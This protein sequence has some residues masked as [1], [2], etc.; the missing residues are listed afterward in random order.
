MTQGSGG[1]YDLSRRELLSAS[2]A[3]GLALATGGCDQFVQAIKDRPTRRN[4]AN[5]SP[6]D[7]ILE[8]YR[9]AIA[10]MQALPTTDQR[11][12]T[13]QASIHYNHCPHTNWFLLP[14]HRMY[15]VYFER[16]CRKLSGDQQFALPYWNWTDDPAVPAVFWPTGDPLNDSTKTIAQGTP[17]L[18]EFVSHAVLEPI[19][20]ETNFLIFGSGKVTGQRDPGSQGPLEATPHNNVHGQIGGHMATYMSPLDP[21]FW[22]HHCMLDFCWVDW[23]L[24]RV[25]NNPNDPVWNNLQITDFVDE[26][27]QPVSLPV[28]ITPLYPIFDYQYEPSQIGATV[29]HR[30]A[31]AKQEQEQLKTF[32]QQGG[33]AEIPVLQRFR[34]EGPSDVGVGR[35]SR[36]SIAVQSSALRDAIESTGDQ[37]L[38][39]T[40]QQV[41]PPAEAGFFV[42]VFV[43]EPGTV[44][45]ETP[46]TDPHY[47][48]SFA[49]FIGDHGMNEG[50]HM[51]PAGFVVDL[52]ETLR[53][54]SRGGGLGQAN[55]LEIQ[56][57]PV[58]YPGRP[59]KELSFTVGG[60][61][62]AIARL[63]RK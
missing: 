40:I 44:T 38:L 32:V 52:T 6:N 20:Q 2:G 60:L 25:N 13:N 28:S 19:L 42:R 8:A 21:I 53:R 62:L 27:N 14:W 5:L 18:A 56:L 22:T 34:V 12:W 57:V 4:I 50:M 35:G 15:L 58:P 46:I 45:P 61:E 41:Q 47:A 54:L 31:K 33:D 63:P 37:R 7:P 29:V 17:I 36:T 49:F 10:A 16:I 48:G 1:F 51:A 59:L 26:N 9:A 39:L 11:N 30:L 3:L 55:Q 43:D 23:N 24:V